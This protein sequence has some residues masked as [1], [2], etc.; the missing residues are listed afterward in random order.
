M[1]CSENWG[2]EHWVQVPQ[3]LKN[4]WGHYSFKPL[5]T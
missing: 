2:D 5:S 1:E 3:Q 4:T